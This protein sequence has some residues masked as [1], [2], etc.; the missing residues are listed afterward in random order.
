MRSWI[1][2][3]TDPQPSEFLTFPIS[4]LGNI[5]RPAYNCHHKPRDTSILSARRIRNVSSGRYREWAGEGAEHRGGV[6]LL[7]ALAALGETSGAASSSVADQD[8]AHRSAV[9][10]VLARR[11]ALT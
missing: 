9:V 6:V 8:A 5:F 7:A 11:L 3:T 1:R 2:G 4:I 10:A